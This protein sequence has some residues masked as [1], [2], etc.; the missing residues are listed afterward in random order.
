MPGRRRSLRLLPGLRLSFGARGPELRIGPRAAGLSAGLD[1]ARLTARLPGTGLRYSR[2]LLPGLPRR[3][4]PRRPG[5]AMVGL[6][7]VLALGLLA[8][9]PA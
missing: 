7:V 4:A 2:R 6:L 1:G 8:V 9:L 3:R 5:P